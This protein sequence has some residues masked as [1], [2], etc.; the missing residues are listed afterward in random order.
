MLDRSRKNQLA[1]L[2]WLLHAAGLGVT[3]AILFVAIALVIRP[4]GDES[5]RV[6]EKIQATTDYVQR[7]PELTAR[8]EHLKR[9]LADR[10]NRR[11]ELM[12][13]IP[14]SAR[15]SEFLTQLAQ[16]ARSTGMAISRY[17]PG[18]SVEEGSHASLGIELKAQASYASICSFLAGLEHLPRL[19]RVTELSIAAAAPDDEQYQVGMTLQ[20]FF[21]ATSEANDG[22]VSHG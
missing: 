19:C 15:E 1:M 8:H 14:D 3:V 21:T 11:A 20:V 9:T 12:A 10:R 4:I 2:S 22:E 16:L 18:E 17:N 6:A 5:R 7:N 13:R